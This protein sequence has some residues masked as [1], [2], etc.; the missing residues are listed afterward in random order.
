MGYRNDKTTG[1]PVGDEAQTIYAVFSGVHYNNK[2]CFDYGNAELVPRDDGA[3][4]ME[5]LYFGSAKGGLNHGGMGPGPWI[6]GDLEQGLWGSNITASLEPTISHTFVTAM[7]KGDSGAAPG[8]MAIKGGD[9]QAGALTVFYDGWRPH[10]YAPM[11]KQGSIILGIGGVS[12]GGAAAMSNPSLA[13][14]PNPKR[15][16]HPHQKG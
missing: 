13:L 15:S 2:C 11:K 6:M 16:A 1:I 5:A 7:F 4:T 10:G 12:F 9:A 8:H 14:T 3:G